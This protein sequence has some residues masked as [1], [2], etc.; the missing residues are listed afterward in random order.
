MT[1][2]ALPRPE[3]V[4]RLVEV[5]ETLG[6]AQRV[7]PE[8]LSDHEVEESLV[9]LTAL[10]SQVS[11]L[12]LAVLGE[13]EQRRIAEKHAATGPEA[14]AAALTGESVGRVAGGLRISRQL[15]ERYHHTREAFAAGELR[16][17]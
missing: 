14:W 17:E 5:R 7:A 2:H 8:Q 16:L 9:E 15:R 4:A 3:L 12:R 13:V 11:S 1:V 10:E 6:D